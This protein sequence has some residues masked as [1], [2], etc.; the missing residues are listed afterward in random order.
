MIKDIQSIN[1]N[2][3]EGKL[4]L[5]AIAKIH[6]ESQPAKTPPAILKQL[7][8]LVA[9]MFKVD[10]VGAYNNMVDACKVNQK[11]GHPHPASTPVPDKKK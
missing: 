9:V 5:A 11:A 10:T 4:L 1:I 3:D 2:T 6:A 7:N 8:M